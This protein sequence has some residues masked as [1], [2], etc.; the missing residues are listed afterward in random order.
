MKMLWLTIFFLLA[1]N[2]FA[3]SCKIE[4][5]DL[6]EALQSAENSKVLTVSNLTDAY[7]NEP[8]R[9]YVQLLSDGSIVIVEQKHCLM[10][11]L[12]ITIL[13]PEGLSTDEVPVK[14]SNVLNKTVAWNKWFKTLDSIK[15]LRSEF[16]SK[17]FQSH[18]GQLGSYSYSLDNKIVTKNE[19]SEA[20]LRLVNIESGIL[21][22]NQIVSLYIGVGGL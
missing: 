5:F 7:S 14:L 21:P 8:I 4:T 10:Y 6:T 22:F 17:R 11:N 15:I 9:R 12:T 20:V 2:I 18:I 1:S 3:E 16:S 19:N 13:L